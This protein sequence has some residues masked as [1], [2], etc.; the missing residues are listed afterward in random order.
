MC[1]RN[2]MGRKGII[3]TK[4]I[5]IFAGSLRKEAYSKSIAR[6]IQQMMPE[7]FDA[8]MVEFGQ[9][10]LFNQD[11]DDQGQTPDSYTAFRQLVDGLDGFVF[12]TPEHNRS[13]PAA[14]KN[15]LDVASRP[16]DANKWSGKPGLVVSISPG[17]V[18]GFGANHH[19]RQV[20]SFLNVDTVQQPELY[21][22]AV[23]TRLD[24]QGKLKDEDT[25][26]LLQQ[27]LEALQAKF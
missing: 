26:A 15:A 27:G 19:L 2:N 17:A 18:G 9:L 13:L 3:V 16:Y 23:H 12:V 22:N 6:A 21:I 20:L 25:R 7:G 24:E 4:K 5:G 8:T 1:A 14:F 10:P 11:F